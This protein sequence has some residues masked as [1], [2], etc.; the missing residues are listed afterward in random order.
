MIILTSAVGCSKASIA[1]DLGCSAGTVAIIRKR[2]RPHGLDGLIPGK[3][4]GRTSG[5]TPEYQAALRTA[6]STPSQELG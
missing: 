6:V 4:R 1:H 2:Y 3:P 5:A